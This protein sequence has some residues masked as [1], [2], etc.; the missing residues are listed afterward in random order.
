M[1]KVK[2][3][4]YSYVG[5]CNYNTNKAL[6]S[7]DKA[8]FKIHDMIKKGD[9]MVNHKHHSRMSLKHKNGRWITLEETKH[10]KI[11]RIMIKFE[12]P[13]K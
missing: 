1:S 4:L 9:L 5:E 6:K 10:G 2:D 7:I 3:T 13:I 8:R 11:I 12:K